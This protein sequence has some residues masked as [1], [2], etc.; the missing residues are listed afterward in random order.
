MRGEEVGEGNSD[1]HT[2]RVRETLVKPDYG[3]SSTQWQNESF[4]DCHAPP[5]PPTAL[6][7]HHPV[8]RQTRVRERARER[9]PMRSSWALPAG[10][11][12]DGGTA[13]ALSHLPEEK[14]WPGRR[15]EGGEGGDTRLKEEWEKTTVGKRQKSECVFERRSVSKQPERERKT[16]GKGKAFVSRLERGRK[17][18]EEEK[19]KKHHVYSEEAK[20]KG[21]WAAP[22][23]A[24]WEGGGPRGEEEE[25]EEEGPA[26]TEQPLLLLAHA[27]LPP[28]WTH[29]CFFFLLLLLLSSSSY[30][31]AFSVLDL[32]KPHLIYSVFFYPTPHGAFIQTS[33][34]SPSSCAPL[35]KLPLRCSLGT[36]YDLY[37]C[38]CMC[39]CVCVFSTS[40]ACH[41][42]E[43]SLHVETRGSERAREKLS[44][45]N[46]AYSTFSWAIMV[47][48][49]FSWDYVLLERLKS[50]QCWQAVISVIYRRI[51]QLQ[52]S[53]FCCILFFLSLPLSLLLSDRCLFCYFCSSSLAIS[54][55][56]PSCSSAL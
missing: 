46:G 54:S 3:E 13:P 39:V 28:S 42:P 18:E 36:V 47:P 44:G 7:P 35:S 6:L 12:G 25:E 30:S 53:H 1:T 55:M 2:H 16:P 20:R 45:P 50:L 49:V 9:A 27:A 51:T 4:L 40:W 14:S 34:L 24:G 37:V 17:E 21:K 23:A 48:D 8:K 56:G 41:S 19:R 22:S 5:L 29:C 33:R 32:I 15:R 11:G 52:R 31:L 38:V 10:G 26:G 43:R